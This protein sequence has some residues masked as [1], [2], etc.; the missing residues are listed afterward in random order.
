MSTAA[1]TLEDKSHAVTP[2]PLVKEET[3]PTPPRDEPA[4]T[5]MVRHEEDPAAATITQPDEGPTS[6]TLTS[7]EAATTTTTKVEEELAV[8]STGQPAEESATSDMAGEDAPI[9]ATPAEREN[10]QLSTTL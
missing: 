4:T 3:T 2:A 7:E 10:Q 6:T 5:A 1:A 9:V 8:A